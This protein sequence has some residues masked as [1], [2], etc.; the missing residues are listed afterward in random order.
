MDTAIDREGVQGR[1]FHENTIQQMFME[2]LHEFQNSP[3]AL[4]PFYI[5]ILTTP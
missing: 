1:V 4:T 5:H 3:E 2:T